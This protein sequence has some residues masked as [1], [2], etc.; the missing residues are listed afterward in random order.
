MSLSDV[1]VIS[2]DIARHHPLLVTQARQLVHVFAAAKSELKQSLEWSLVTVIYPYSHSTTDVWILQNPLRWGFFIH[3]GENLLPYLRPP[4][5]P[6]TIRAT[7]LASCFSFQNS[8]RPALLVRVLVLMVLMIVLC[9][10]GEC[11]FW[12]YG[13][14]RWGHRGKVRE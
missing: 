9:C 7:V 12:W 11:R 5:T 14:F 2:P 1:T 13:G 6:Q 8:T 10:L 3:S 4:R